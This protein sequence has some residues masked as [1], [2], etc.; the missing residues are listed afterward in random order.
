MCVYTARTNYYINY[1]K[2]LEQVRKIFFN[3]L[4]VWM[5]LKKEQIYTRGVYRD[6][7]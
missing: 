6:K 3:E 1:K 4:K 5:L 2:V 7:R